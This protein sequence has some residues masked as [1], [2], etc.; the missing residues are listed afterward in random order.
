LALTRYEKRQVERGW[1]PSATD[2]GL[3]QEL[4]LMDLDEPVQDV[5]PEG[6]QHAGQQEVGERAPADHVPPPAVVKRL[7][8]TL[9]LLQVQVMLTAASCGATGNT[10]RHNNILRL[11]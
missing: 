10:P 9:L 7:V 11:I 3:V 1:Y 8:W 6:S 2:D 5:R 4:E